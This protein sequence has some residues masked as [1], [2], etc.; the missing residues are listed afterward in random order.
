MPSCGVCLSVLRPSRSC[1][2]SKQLKIGRSCYETRIGNR[3]QA[4][5]CYHFQWPWVCPK[6]HFRV[7]TKDTI[8][9][10]LCDSWQLNLL[11]VQSLL[12]VQDAAVLQT[13]CQDVGYCGKTVTNPV[14]FRGA[15]EKKHIFW[16]C[17]SAGNYRPMSA[18]SCW[19]QLNCLQ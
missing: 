15:C 16:G 9:R 3:S 5:E 1:I 6:L 14:A 12:G 10:P 13:C 17:V 11:S 18:I 2:V 4:F 7:S 19:N 8:A